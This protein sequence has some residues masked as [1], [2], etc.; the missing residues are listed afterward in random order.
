MG[1]QPPLLAP[2]QQSFPS[3]LGQAVSG[4]A[5]HGSRFHRGRRSIAFPVAYPV[6]VDPYAYGGYQQDPNVT[7]VMP[8]PQP[9]QQYPGPPAPPVTINQHF[10]Q[11]A[12]PPSTQQNSSIRTY[13]APVTSNAPPPAPVEEEEQPLFLIALKDSTVYTAVAYWVQDS[14][15]HYVSPKN[16]QNQVSLD[17]VD[18]ALTERLNRGRPGEVKLPAGKD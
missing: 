15:L 18:R 3:R 9:A 14:T 8:Q 11:Q 2:F 16:R 7:V 1:T 12:A 10:G 6:F 13:D 5:G 17:L 4:F